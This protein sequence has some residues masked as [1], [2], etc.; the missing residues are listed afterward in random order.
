MQTGKTCETYAKGITLPPFHH[1]ESYYGHAEQRNSLLM[2]QNGPTFTLCRPLDKAF[3]TI[4]ADMIELTNLSD[5][6]K[7]KIQQL[8]YTGKQIEQTKET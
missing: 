4:K 7:Y 8:I 3:S 1:H 6:I 5:L 2:S